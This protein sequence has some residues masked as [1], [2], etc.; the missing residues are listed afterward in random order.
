[1]KKLLYSIMAL[2]GV[3]ATS[4]TQEHIEAQFVPGNVVAPVLGTI[5]GT[6]LAEDGANI[7]VEY[8]KADFGVATASTEALYTA[9][10]ANMADQVKIAAEFKEGTITFTQKDLN[11]AIL[12]LGAD[13]QAENTLY[14]A[15]VANL[16]TDKGAAVAGTECMSNIVSATF[17]GY[18]AEVL[19]TEKYEHVWVIG[20]YCGWDHSKTQFL[21]DYNA[22]GTTF[23]GVIDF[24]DAEGVSLA[25]TGFKL[26]GI[27]GWDDSC[28][29]GEETKATEVDEPA[30]I[31]LIT[32]GGSQDI[33]RYGMRFYGFEFDKTTLVLKKLWG[34]N[35]IGVI[36][37]FNEW[38]GDVVMSYNAKWNR[39]YADVEFAADGGFKFRADADWTLNWGVDCAQGGDN[40]AVTAGNYRVYFNPVTGLIEL[41]SSKYGTTED[42][43]IGGGNDEGGNDEGGE[44]TPA[45]VEVGK[46]AL[47]GVGGDWDHDIYMYAGENGKFY[48]PVVS[49]EGE[50]KLRF[51]ND[52][53]INRGGAFAA[54]GEPFAV[55]NGGNNIAVPAG[56]YVVVYD[57]V[58][59]A[60][61]VVN[62]AEGWGLIGDALANGW[63]TDTFYAFEGEAGVYTA[64]AY[65]GEG[66]F[67]FRA[68]AGWDTNFGGTFTEYG[69][70]FT[71]EAGGANIALSESNVWVV[72]TL[73]TNAQTIT[74][75]KL[76]AGRWGVVGVVNGMNWDGDVFMWNDGSVW[77]SAPFRVDGDFKIRENAAWD[78]D[79][80][81]TFA[82]FDTA[83]EAVK[84]GSN[85]SLGGAATYATLVYDPTAETI[86]VSEFK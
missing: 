85:I 65:V 63:D 72:A 55:T 68:N 56:S 24:A 39:F 28:N 83:F 9:L 53:V 44:E 15:V 75:N 67:K 84:G 51:D 1:M 19:P 52:W 22:T 57:S 23:S 26:T 48:S 66:G 61:T 81:G 8:T 31:Q 33:M 6:T 43:E 7:T 17:V 27:A 4:C 10:D 77:K 86:T 76:F 59:D 42:T 37:D 12:N 14:F 5:E 3:V 64:I 62:A 20:N 70:A 30:S 32:G 41:N 58:A 11:T 49:F 34:A 21:F 50:F 54:V 16:N 69:V 35:Q 74:I 71:A 25:N 38:G 2:A 80:G 40:I 47:I 36:G 29:W 79:R 60:V 82:A 13:A 46:W 78:N 73:D 45:N 18:N